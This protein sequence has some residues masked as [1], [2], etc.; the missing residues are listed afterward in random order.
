M[1]AAPVPLWDASNDPALIAF[2]N[3]SDPFLVVPDNYVIVRGGQAPM[4]AAGTEFSASMGAS[5]GEAAA[6]VPHNQIRS[7]TAGAIRANGGTVEL[8]PVP[9]PA[10]IMNNRHVHVV[11]AGTTAFFDPPVRNPVPKVDRIR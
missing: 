7:A 2:R 5:L 4:P 9:T 11:E 3:G 1:S 6:G 10:Q 8:V